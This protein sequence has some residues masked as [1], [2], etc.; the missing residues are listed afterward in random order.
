MKANFADKMRSSG[1]KIV[2]A[3]LFVG[4]TEVEGLGIEEWGCVES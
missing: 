3:L 2:G 1:G 4:I